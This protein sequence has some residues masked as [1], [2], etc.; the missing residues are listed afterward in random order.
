MFHRERTQK[1]G[2]GQAEYGR[3]GAYAD[4][5]RKNGDEGEAGIGGQHADAV[6]NVVPEGAHIFLLRRTRRI[7]CSNFVKYRSLRLAVRKE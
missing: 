2:V 4:G 7:G 5:E 3:I 1:H 6:A